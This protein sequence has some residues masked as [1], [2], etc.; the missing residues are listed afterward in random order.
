MMMMMMMGLRWFRAKSDFFV[1]GSICSLRDA[2]IKRAASCVLLLFCPCPVARVY[3]STPLVRWSCGYVTWVKTI[4][5]CCIMWPRIAPGLLVTV[6][7]Y[8]SS[9]VIILCF[10]EL[11]LVS[12]DHGSYQADTSRTCQQTS[13]YSTVNNSIASDL[14]SVHV[15]CWNCV[16][17]TGS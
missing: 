9:A 11:D 13:L 1:R 16:I 17:S 14:S 8:H 5:C 15:V 4:T 6:G 12:A 7:C 10:C 2:S 3:P